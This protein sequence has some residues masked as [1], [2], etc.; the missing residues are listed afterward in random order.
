ML[1]AARLGDQISHTQQRS[2]LI[3]GMIVGAL[4]VGA[5]VLAVASGGTAIPALI[6]VGAVATGAA[7]GGGIGQLIGGEMTVPK[8]AINKA[9][10]TVFVNSRA[11][12]AARACV[13]TALCQ[14]HVL[15]LIA[16]GSTT[17]AIEGF[18]AARVSDIGACSF[19]ISQGSSN[20]FIGG[21]QGA[22]AGIDIA[23]E[24]EPWLS[25]L[26]RVIGWVGG[27]CLLGPIY[28]LRVAIASLIGGEI[29][30]HF[31]G[32]IGQ[33][34]G[35][36]WGGVAGSVLGGI[37]GGGIPLRPGV[38][39]FINRLEVDP[40]R[41]GTAGGNL[42]LKPKMA[43]GEIDEYGK[44]KSKTG[45]GLLDRDHQPSKGSLKTRAQELNGGD[46]LSPTQARRI[47]NEAQAVAVPKNVHQAGPTYG[48]KNTPALQSSDASDLAAAARRDA[49]AMIRNGRQ[50]DPNNLPTYENA[51]GRMTT[52]TNE[53]YDDWLRGIL[54][55]P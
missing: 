37:I 48:G 8:G 27:L 4:I 17:V 9:A 30:A 15:Q 6:A 29:G 51:A 26:H 32:Q 54:R 49:D 16:T 7:V 11:T 34:L 14:D 31:G 44:L 40:N 20:V 55:E 13:D 53:Q 35:G 18:P 19:A 21:A 12:P 25:N 50:L 39:S 23:P 10:T 5:V 1:K 46:P 52:M 41:L 2:G 43:L 38:R 47:E 45:E 33:S 3:T 24:V 28:G 36:K 22:C 42:R